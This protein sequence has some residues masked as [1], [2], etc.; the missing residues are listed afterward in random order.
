M[1]FLEHNISKCIYIKSPKCMF[2]IHS[3]VFQKITRNQIS[4]H[5][6][7]LSDFKFLLWFFFFLSFAQFFSRNRKLSLY[8]V[9]CVCV[10]VKWLNRCYENSRQST[11]WMLLFI[12]L[13][14]CRHLEV[15][16]TFG[17]ITSNLTKPVHE[18]NKIFILMFQELQLVP[19]RWRW[20]NKTCFLSWGG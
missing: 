7:P 5:I 16:R 6:T 13:Q 14:N 8:L 10:C 3:F 12:N 15:E 2:S 4:F 20:R 17:V 18:L 19:G 11:H 1:L 9:V